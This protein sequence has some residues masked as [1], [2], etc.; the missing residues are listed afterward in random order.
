VTVI[1][2]DL[3]GRNIPDSS[4]DNMEPAFVYLANENIDQISKK[5]KK[6]KKKKSKA[7]KMGNGED[8]HPA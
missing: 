3:D 2:A 8:D 7:K 5:K 4:V 6:P 1:C